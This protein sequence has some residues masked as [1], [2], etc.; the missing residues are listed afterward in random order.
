ML[1]PLAIPSHD[2]MSRSG[3]QCGINQTGRT[4]D[5]EITSTSSTVAIPRI[6]PE[7]D[8]SASVTE[9]MLIR[10]QLKTSTHTF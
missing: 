10:Q 8:I 3:G 7:I 6:L 1:A 9:G 5:F 4:P 2:D